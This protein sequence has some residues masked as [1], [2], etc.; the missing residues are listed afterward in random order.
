MAVQFLNIRPAEPHLSGFLFYR[1]DNPLD[2]SSSFFRTDGMRFHRERPQARN[3]SESY[4]G[5]KKTYLSKCNLILF[6]TSQP[7]AL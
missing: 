7:K 5:L 4:C 1:T 3:E 2:S 6:L